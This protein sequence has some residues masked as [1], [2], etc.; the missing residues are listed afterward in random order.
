MEWTDTGVVLSARRHGE[1][2]AIVQ[3]LT[4]GHG[5]HAGLVRG[6]AGRKARAIL[7]PG[8]EVEATWRARLEDQL[9]TFTLELVRPRAAL[10]LDD[11]GRLGA[12]TAAMETA[13][14]SLAEREPHP[15]THARL[16][17]LMDAIED[18]ALWPFAYVHWELGLLADLGF[19][20]DLAGGE[21]SAISGRTGKPLGAAPEG[22]RRLPVPGFLRGGA[23]PAEPAARRLALREG[24][25]LTG[26]FLER[27]VERPERGLPARGRLLGRLARSDTT[28]GVRSPDGH[29]GA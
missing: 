27:A 25:A 12:L 17:I 1:T 22:E 14:A 21:T 2:S 18:D 24:L 9:G 16:V 26:H 5:R 8:N 23:P 13:E 10:V 20:L 28:S 3:L 15:R 29:A 19:G 6:G 4:R 7:Q 11:A